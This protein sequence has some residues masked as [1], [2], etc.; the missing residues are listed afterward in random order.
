MTIYFTWNSFVQTQFIARTDG[1]NWTQGFTCSISISYVVFRCCISFRSL[2]VRF[3]VN[4]Q[5]GFQGV[6]P[7]SLRM[8]SR[9]LTQQEQRELTEMSRFA[10][11]RCENSEMVSSTERQVSVDSSDD[12]GITLCCI[13]QQ[14]SSSRK[15]IWWRSSWHCS[16]GADR[17]RRAKNT[18]LLPLVLDVFIFQA[19]N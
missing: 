12:S 7:G 13:A 5:P 1:V 9:D 18:Y 16:N 4:L 10:L 3:H 6:R 8:V 2:Q 14:R 11:P 17:E 19:V 15:L